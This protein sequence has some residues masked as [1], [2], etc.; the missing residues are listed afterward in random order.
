MKDNKKFKR[1]TPGAKPG[2]P[3]RSTRPVCEWCGSPLAEEGRPCMFCTRSNGSKAAQLEQ[4]KRKMM[5]RKFW[6]IGIAAAFVMIIAFITLL[7]KG[8]NVDPV[9]L[10][11]SSEDLMDGITEPTLE[12]YTNAF[13]VKIPIYDRDD[14]EETEEPEAL[15]D[16]T[17]EISTM[18]QMIDPFP[19][20]SS[21][22]VIP[23]T[24]AD[25]AS[26]QPVI[27]SMPDATAS[28]G[29][30]VSEKGAD[31]AIGG[32]TY[33]LNGC[34]YLISDQTAILEHWGV[35]STV[36]TI[37]SSVRG[38][39]VVGI[40]SY[41][42]ENC[43]AVEYVR[44]GQ[45]VQHIDGNAFSGINV[46]E[47]YI[48]RSVS[49][50]DEN[51]FSVV[52][53]CICKEDSYAWSRMQDIANRVVAGD[54]LSIEL[55]E[56]PSESG[57]NLADPAFVTNEAPQPTTAIWLTSPWTDSGS[58]PADTSSA[59]YDSSVPQSSTE[60]VWT[61]PSEV[62]TDNPFPTDSV[63]PTDEPEESPAPVPPESEEVTSVPETRETSAEDSS[64]KESTSW[65]DFPEDEP[66]KSTAE[67]TTD[68]ST[69][70]GP[71]MEYTPLSLKWYQS[72]IDPY[73]VFT[74]KCEL[75]QDLDGDG[76]AEYYTVLV[77]SISGQSEL[78]YCA[79][80]GVN[81]TVDLLPS[82]LEQASLV[83]ITTVSSDDTYPSLLA[84][85]VYARNQDPSVVLYLVYEN[86]QEKLLSFSGS[87]IP[88]LSG[89]DGYCF[90]THAET[91]HLLDDG[92]TTG[93]TMI[94]FY[95][96]QEED[97]SIAELTGSPLSY[98]ELLRLNG[99]E[100]VRALCLA[101]LDTPIVAER[102]TIRANGVLELSF[103]TESVA[104]EAYPSEQH[105]YTY[106]YRYEPEH[107]VSSRPLY[108]YEGV[109][110]PVC[111]PFPCI[112]GAN[113][114][115]GEPESEP[116]P[117]IEPAETPEL[118]TDTVAR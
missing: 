72:V 53:T 25:P 37:P 39:P 48:P 79:K 89:A 110:K 2:N 49:H 80:D 64:L 65:F 103:I 54:Y 56:I 62:L 15:V 29:D 105:V 106:G 28:T 31:P 5:R 69:A 99:G 108:E 8:D 1:I 63:S 116:A 57:I 85:T 82:E 42:F 111:T 40:G 91:L 41:A 36:I 100:Q 55:A 4:R 96:R 7:K 11:V 52:L 88:E 118:L 98:D 9:I 112:D 66:V 93:D 22:D 101:G 24:S 77:D 13:G 3:E 117:G 113:L 92:T 115:P 76:F 71:S 17:T 70:S 43:H 20:A 44:I 32:S 97:G 109:P 35:N 95:L 104:D 46:K 47:I 60:D 16:E 12:Y 23:T 78:K 45:Q 84:L 67:E 94:Y 58:V 27:W 34:R 87:Y 102:Y 114:I 50:I 14:P 73:G 90:Q 86:E 18:E 75:Y 38:L 30:P 21:V 83:P 33:T 19:T 81:V 107:G 74:R 61:L 10:T 59:P 68:A 26:E 6:F 51:A